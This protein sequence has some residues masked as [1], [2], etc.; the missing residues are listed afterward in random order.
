[1]TN[2]TDGCNMTT[3]SDGYHVYMKY[4]KALY[5]F[6]LLKVIPQKTNFNI[7]Y[8]VLERQVLGDGP[9]SGGLGQLVVIVGWWSPPYL[10]H[11]LHHTIHYMLHATPH[12]TLHAAC[13][14]TQYTTCSMLHYTI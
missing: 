4:K 14:T 13:Y 2:D 3:D 6:S 8:L 5:H 11:M 12:N 7:E 10:S 9:W 1:M